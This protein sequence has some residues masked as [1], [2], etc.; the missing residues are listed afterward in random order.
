MTLVYS[1]LK[2]AAKTPEEF[3]SLKNIDEA[4]KVNLCY[5]VFATSGS[6]MKNKDET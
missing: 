4:L 5:T 2:C 3:I 1:G 6:M